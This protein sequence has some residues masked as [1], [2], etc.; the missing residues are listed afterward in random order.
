MAIRKTLP[1][2][3]A[4]RALKSTAPFTSDTTKPSPRGSRSMPTRSPRIA[5]AASSARVW[6]SGGGAT[7]SLRA[8][9]A[10]LVRHSPGAATLRAA[11]TTRPPATTIRRSQPSGGTCSCARTPC[12]E[13]HG[14]CAKCAS[15]RSRSSAVGQS[16]TSRPHPLAAS[17]SSFSV[18]RS[19]PSS[20]S[21]TSSRPSAMS[22]GSRVR[23]AS[24]G[25]S[26]VA[27]KPSEAAA[28]A[29]A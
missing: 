12:S 8:P 24:R 26:T 23:S 9:S 20:S 28:P 6:A 21:R 29:S 2:L 10:T 16:T 14:R 25:G 1:G 19:T 4:Y 18:P 22:P 27:G 5:A 11:P 15:S 3:S 13:N 7:G 17:C